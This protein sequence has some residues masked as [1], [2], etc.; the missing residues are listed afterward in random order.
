MTSVSRASNV[1]EAKEL[2][3]RHGI[4]V[5]ESVLD[6][7]GLE[8]VRCALRQGI[9]KDEGAGVQVRG[10]PFDPD[11]HN[12][13]LFD[14]IGKDPVFV[15]LVEHPIAVELVRHVIGSPFPL[16][17]FSANLNGPGSGSM[18]MH[19][20]QGYV[21]APWPPYLLAGPVARPE[22]PGDRQRQT[23]K[24][25]NH[26]ASPAELLLTE[27]SGRSAEC[28]SFRANLLALM[29][30]TI[31]QYVRLVRTERGTHCAG[32]DE[33]CHHNQRPP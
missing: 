12:I 18:I 6:A 7:E 4:C 2:L 1:N 16:S 8:R 30:T 23:H 22:A 19:A 14:L 20:D 10:F 27:T 11:T 26:R 31:P 24:A 25:D 28:A 13:R 33:A 9:A 5:M 15:E 21:P 17:N 3:D 29:N 32:G